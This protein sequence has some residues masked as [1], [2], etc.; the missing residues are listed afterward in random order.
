M[1]HITNTFQLRRNAF[2]KT[3]A[4]PLDKTIVPGSASVCRWSPSETCDVVD[5]G[6]CCMYTTEA[7]AN[8]TSS[9][10]ASRKRR[11]TRTNTMLVTVVL[12][13]VITWTPFHIIDMIL[14]FRNGLV[15]GR[16]RKLVSLLCRVVAFSSACVN[17]F[18]YGWMND[19]Y[20]TSFLTLIAPLIRR[21][22][23]GQT[24]APL[25][26]KPIEVSMNRGDVRSKAAT[27]GDN[28]A[29][30]A[31]CHVTAEVEVVIGDQKTATNHGSCEHRFVDNELGGVDR[32][33]KSH[34]TADGDLVS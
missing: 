7:R 31:Q 25:K 33:D 18:L 2:S 32:I 10:E 8:M 1:S 4:R 28:V 34:L 29:D 26:M 16:Y 12:V 9:A 27:V 6:A 20:R 19:N 15:P 30:N 13:F 23:L 14:E 24:G 21:C 22:Q 3:L 17:P 11:R 5:T